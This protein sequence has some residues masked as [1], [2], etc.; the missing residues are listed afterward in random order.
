MVLNSDFVSLN[1]N[2]SY[3]KK[4]FICVESNHFLAF[5]HDEAAP[6]HIELVLKYIQI[7][8]NNHINNKNC[9]ISIF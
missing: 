6:L 3:I 5:S 1:I 8:D 2:L 4:G 9:Y 7:Q